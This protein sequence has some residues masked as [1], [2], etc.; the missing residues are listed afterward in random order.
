[1][2]T[3]KK[4]VSK[5]KRSKKKAKKTEE[6]LEVKLLSSKDLS[7]FIT[8][9]G[10]VDRGWTNYRMILDGYELWASG[11]RKRYSLVGP[12]DVEQR[13][14]QIVMRPETETENDG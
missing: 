4:K 7:E 13:T 9:R 3:R 14:G 12:F 11:I 6:S 8:R 10:A 2:P 1:M 5:K